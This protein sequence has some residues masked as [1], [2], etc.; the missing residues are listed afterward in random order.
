VLRRSVSKIGIVLAAIPLVYDGFKACCDS[1]HEKMKDANRERHKFTRQLNL[2]HIGLRS[3]IKKLFK[4]LEIGLRSGQLDALEPHVKGSEFMNFWTEISKASPRVARTEITDSEIVLNVIEDMS[5]ILR[6]VVKHIEPPGD[7]DMSWL[8]EIMI[9]YEQKL[10]PSR[11]FIEKFMFTARSSGR[12]ALLEQL[13]RNIDALALKENSDSLT[14][15]KSPV[16][17][18][19]IIA[20]YKERLDF[21]NRVRDRSRDLYGSLFEIWNCP[22]HLSPC[23]MLRLERRTQDDQDI[24]FI[25]ILTFEDPFKDHQWSYQETQIWIHEL[26]AILRVLF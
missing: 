9:N 7:M 19:V 4:K 8:R 14:V 18:P 26:Y 12:I 24:R 6:Q 17:L 20:N 16:R 13:K 3:G 25:L 22:C 1:S 2:V 5:D 23:A 21:L 10:L 15:E 11:D